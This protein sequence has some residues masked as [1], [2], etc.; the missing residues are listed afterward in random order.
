MIKKIV[1]QILKK[2]YHYLN[3]R[4]GLVIYYFKH[5]RIQ[6]CAQKFHSLPLERKIVFL[7]FEGKGYG[8]NPKYIAE[9]LIKRKFD[10]E[11]VWLVKENDQFMPCNIR[12]VDIEKR[13]SFKELATARV[14]VNNVKGDINFKKREGQYYIQTWHA[15]FS[16]KLLE[17]DASATLPKSYLL[18]SKYNSED[19]DLFISN[20]IAQ[21]EEYKRAFWCQCEILESGLP[22]N[23]LFFKYTS[24]MKYN[25]RE[26]IGIKN[27]NK[28]LMY[29]PTFRGK[30]DSLE[31]YGLDFEAIKEAI[32]NKFGGEWTILVR[33]HP[34]II[35]KVCDNL[36]YKD[37]S[38]YPDMQD[39]LLITDILITDYSSSIFDIIEMNKIAFVYANDIDRYQSIRGLKTDYFELPFGIA[40]NNNDLIENIKRFDE[41]KYKQM[42]QNVKNR[43]CTF[44]NGNAAEM[45]VDKILKW[46]EVYE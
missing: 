46:M 10:G 41:D 26:K 40:E 42:I 30:N 3:D 12:Q 35:T 25:I 19:S 9:E 18:E 43:Y 29:A 13:E 7:N 23:D 27:H 11:L 24:E 38:K 16:P 22:R 28:I 32:C 8:C 39:L 37:V 5:K 36:I 33:M 4:I 1:K 17:K 44:D 20:S 2:P 6:F 14:I 15:G 31:E 21:T 45:V 34:N